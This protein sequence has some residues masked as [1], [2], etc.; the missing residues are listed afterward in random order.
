MWP[1]VEFQESNRATA[2]WLG[3]QGDPLREA[4]L[5]AGFNTNA[6][7]LTDELVR[8]WARAGT[9]TGVFWPTNQLSQWLLK[10]FIARTADE[11]LVMGLVTPASNQVDNASLSDLSRGLAGDTASCF[12]AGNCWGPPP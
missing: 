4:A 7:F 3:T 1:R 12:P 8:T 6:L 2:R 10:R 11:W 5:R 9:D